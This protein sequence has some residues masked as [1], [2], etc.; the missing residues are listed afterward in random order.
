MLRGL[1]N[2]KKALLC[3]FRSDLLYFLAFMVQ[4]CNMP[5]TLYIDGKVFILK[6]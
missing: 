2:K 3:T 4:F 5:F 1:K 6:R